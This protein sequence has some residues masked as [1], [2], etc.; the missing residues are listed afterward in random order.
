[1]LTRSDRFIPDN[2]F[3]ALEPIYEI[4]PKDIENRIME[5]LTP[6]DFR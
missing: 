4:T 5:I 6:T 1:M 3:S 2:T